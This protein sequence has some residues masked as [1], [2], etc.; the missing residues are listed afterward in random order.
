MLPK[1]L[2]DTLP[3]LYMAIGAL[4]TA[5]LESD[6]KFLPALLFFVAGGMVLLYRRTAR[7]AGRPRAHTQP[8]HPRHH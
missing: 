2:Y 6:L 4:T 3:W 5:L 7:P 1:G 8:A